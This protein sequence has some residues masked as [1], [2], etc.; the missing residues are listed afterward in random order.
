MPTWTKSLAIGIAAI[1]DQHKELFERADSLITAMK[2]GRPAGEVR[3]LV[4]FLEE[5]CSCHFRSEEDLMALENHAGLEEHRTEHAIFTR[6]FQQISRLFVAKGPCLS[7]TIELQQLICR[8]LVHHVAS[9]DMK[10]G[11]AARAQRA[12]ESSNAAPPAAAASAS[13]ARKPIANDP[14]PERKRVFK[15]EFIERDDRR[16][17]RLNFT[18]LVHAELLEAFTVAGRTI[19]SAPRSSLRILTVL[20]SPIT[21]ESADAFK[22]YALRNRTHVLASAIVGTSFWKVIVTDL[23]SRGRDDLML[24]EHEP[25][26]MQWLMSR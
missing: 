5:Y 13:G 19:L 15:P 25:E 11:G 10:L 23:F 12:P 26:A 20:A 17:M 6:Q 9:M 7:V 18:G 8:W 4:R 14:R 3:L 24:F 22:R 1:D 2:Q 16:I 21:N